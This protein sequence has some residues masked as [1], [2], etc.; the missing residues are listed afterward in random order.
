MNLSWETRRVQNRHKRNTVRV[1]I[2]GIAKTLGEWAE[3]YGVPQGRLRS[4]FYKGIALLPPEARVRG[5]NKSKKEA[6]SS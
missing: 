5:P 1:E 4:R 2:N 3:F 6:L